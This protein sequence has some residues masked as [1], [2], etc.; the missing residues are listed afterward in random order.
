MKQAGVVD[1]GGEMLVDLQSL[2]RISIWEISLFR[3]QNR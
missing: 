3:L 1:L 2:V